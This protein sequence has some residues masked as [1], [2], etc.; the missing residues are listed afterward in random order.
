MELAGFSAVLAFMTSALLCHNPQAGNEANDRD[1]IEAALKLAG[2]DV[3]YADVKGEGF[4]DAL[5]KAVDLV[6]VAGGDGTVARVLTQLRERS[7]PIAILPLG[8]ANNFARSLGIAGTPQELVETW[9]TDHTSPVSIANATGHWG[10]SLFVEAY[11]I[12]VFPQFLLDG[13][14]MGKKGKKPEGAK[15]LQQGRKL[16]RKAL[17]RA[18]PIEIVLTM[19]KQ[20]KELCV[21]GIEVCNIAFTGPG[22]PIATAADVTD[23]KLDVVI[24]DSDSR[25]AVMDWLESPM[26]GTPP[27]LTR[28]SA[29]V[30]LTFHNAPTR[31]DDEAFTASAGKFSVDLACEETSVRIVVP[32]KHP[33]QKA[34]EK[35][36]GAA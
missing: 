24:I 1:S 8:T 31:L 4:T 32:V 36:A 34:L 13:K 3:D 33:S 20:S 23:K 28:K 22:L 30:E 27:F 15:S 18:D 16:L 6:V 14:K 19:G 11:G 5:Q 12:G 21:L 26:D 29:Q 35:K 7:V 10:T 9:D 25:E 17:K 2:Y